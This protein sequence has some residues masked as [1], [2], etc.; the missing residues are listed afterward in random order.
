MLAGLHNSVGSRPANIDWAMRLAFPILTGVAALLAAC[1]ADPH[2]QAR[3]LVQ[4]QPGDT[5]P[6]L[7]PASAPARDD[8]DLS[9]VAISPGIKRACGIA[10]SDASFEYNSARVRD[11]DRAILRQL[12]DCFTTGPLKGRTMQL[13]GRADP[14]GELEYNYLLGQWRADNVKVALINAGT[15]SAQIATTSRGEDEASGRDEASWA[16]DRRVDI[17]LG[18]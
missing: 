13:V 8:P 5:T 4:T 2:A 9:N 7:G 17:Q 10:D 18:R 6:M 14:R 1:G 11:R 15:K 12:A 3:S 16:R